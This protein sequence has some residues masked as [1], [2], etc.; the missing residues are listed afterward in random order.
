MSRKS[1]DIDLGEFNLD[2]ELDFDL[3]FDPMGMDI[4]EDR[5]P[6]SVIPKAVAEGAMNAF[7]GPGK[8][9]Q[10]IKKSLPE[11][12][13]SA[14]ETYDSIASEGR[15]IAQTARE[16]VRTTKR[17]I[18][19]AGRDILPVVKNFMPK[20]LYD[21]LYDATKEYTFSDYDPRQ[22]E[23]EAATANIFDNPERLSP[24][25]DRQTADAIMQQKAEGEVKDQ[26]R[27]IRLKQITNLLANIGQDSNELV[28][29]QRTVT[30]D[31]RKK[32]LEL[33]HRQFFALTDLLEVTKTSNE[34]IVP[35]LES[36]VKNTAL[37]DY[38]KEEF[39]E[40]T[41]ALMKRKVAEFISPANFFKDY[42]FTV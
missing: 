24:K 39:G 17:E 29:Y 32:I 4:P 33:Q 11:N 25:L 18:K 28:G 10:L 12:Y 38:A 7:I 2:D 9:R 41:S 31:Y 22:A 19:R 36:I 5:N 14:Y 20:K 1:K 40:I 27:D 15:K 21:R 13:Q 23:M 34:K 37:P 16:E 42:I 35:S 30:T 8:R 3:D 6:I 26:I